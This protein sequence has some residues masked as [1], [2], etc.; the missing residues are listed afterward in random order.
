M[1][2]TAVVKTWQ[3]TSALMAGQFGTWGKTVRTRDT[4]H[5]IQHFNNLCFY[6]SF[7]LTQQ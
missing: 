2:H 4:N 3:D 5:T 1:L 7:V 6:E